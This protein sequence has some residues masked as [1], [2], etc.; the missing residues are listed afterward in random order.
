MGSEVGGK[1]KKKVW[2]TCMK[3]NQENFLKKM[4][5][6]SRSPPD[7]SVL[8]LL[9]LLAASGFSPPQLEVENGFT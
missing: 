4:K 1:K 2:T 7:L 3:N 9:C 6:C 5:R 8:V